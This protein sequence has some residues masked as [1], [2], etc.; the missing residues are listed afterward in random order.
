[1]RHFKQLAA[2]SNPTVALLSASFLA[3]GIIMR[4]ILYH[5]ILSL[6][7]LNYICQ[8]NGWSSLKPNGLH[9]IKLFIIVGIIIYNF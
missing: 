6:L 7:Y 4:N 3:S 1:M 9:V 5:Y 8:S 2:A